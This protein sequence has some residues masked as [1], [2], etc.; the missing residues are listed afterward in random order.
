MNNRYALTHLT[1]ILSMCLLLLVVST[2]LLGQ[3]RAMQRQILVYIAADSL[4][5]P[6]EKLQTE[7]ISEIIFS[8]NR[9][10]IAFQNIPLEKIEKTFPETGKDELLIENSSG[11]KIRKPN[12]ERVFTIQLKNETSVKEVI[13]RLKSEP[14]VLFAEPH[15]DL[16]LHSDGLYSQQWHL[17]NTGQSS[18]TPDADIDAPEAWQIFT[19]SSSV[20]LAILDTGVE[21]NHLDLSGKSSGDTPESYPY[22]GYAHGTHVAGIAGAKLGGGD[23][24]G[25]DDGVQIIS[26]KV[27]SGHRYDYSQGRDV[28]NWAGDNNGYNKIISVVNNGADVLNHSYGGLQF[29]TIL[30]SAFVYA[31][32]MNRLL[33]ASM[34]NNNSTIFSYPA[35]YGQGVL[36]VGSIIHTDS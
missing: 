17:N 32:K 19:G 4:E 22:N 30:R 23:V 29:S 33:V 15:S 3:N 7:S 11:I 2:S 28:P 25:V 12:W 14:S 24:R 27:F 36:A 21:T 13:N 8:S 6:L 20:K 16:R 18:G 26:R 10:R 5:L 35:A 1:V 34:G 9:L 31:Y